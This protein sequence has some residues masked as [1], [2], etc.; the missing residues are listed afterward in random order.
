MVTVRLIRY[1]G[2][3]HGFAAEVIERRQHVGGDPG[4]LLVEELERRWRFVGWGSRAR[5][6]SEWD[7]QLNYPLDGKA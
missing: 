5:V 3:W 6:Y 7:R 2:R 4:L 1:A